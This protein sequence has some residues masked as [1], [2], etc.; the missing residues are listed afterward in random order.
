MLPDEAARA[1]V[2]ALT[3]IGRRAQPSEVAETIAFLLSPR[4]S[5]I[6]GEIV[7]VDGG[8]MMD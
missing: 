3:P 8:V 1:H 4:A 2:A 5:Y 6:L 7:N